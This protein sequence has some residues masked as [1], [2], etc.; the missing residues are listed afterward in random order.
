MELVL[1]SVKH[2]IKYIYLTLFFGFLITP[3]SAKATGITFLKDGQWSL[4]LAQAKAQNKPIFLFGHTSW[5]GYCKQMDKEVLTTDQA[6]KAFNPT[7]INI[8]LD[9]EKGDG[10]AL[11]E[12]YNITGFPALLYFNAKGE[13]LHKVI[14]ATD[15]NGL[16]STARAAADPYRQFYKL[17]KQVLEGTLDPSRFKYWV[18]NA[19]TMNEEGLDDLITTYLA[20][21]PSI[22]NNE[23]LFEIFFFTKAL[24]TEAQLKELYEYLNKSSVE[25][26]L[27]ETMSEQLLI[28]LIAMASNFSSDKQSKELDFIAFKIYISKF[29]PQSAELETQKQKIKY[30]KEKSDYNKL[31]SE[32]AI[33]IDS[34]KVKPSAKELCVLIGEYSNVLRHTE[35]LASFI[36][37]INGYVLKPEDKTRVC[38]KTMALLYLYDEQGNQEM[39]NKL[40]AQIINDKN[41]PAYLREEAVFR[42][43]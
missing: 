29:L 31:V 13:V 38:Y 7:F 40:A 10:L 2:T 14:G 12:K 22:V 33:I 42:A 11:K 5:C 6:G 35:S 26:V 18:Y 8:S 34:P 23:D 24:P 4:A 43:D 36:Q 21:Q 27:K 28:K 32:L 41:T 39:V 37:K 30:Y 15:Y 9:M 25:R 19:S 1:I 17:K 3:D 16:I 20:K